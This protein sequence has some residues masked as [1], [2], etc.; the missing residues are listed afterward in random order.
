MR[1]FNQVDVLTIGELSPQ[2]TYLKLSCIGSYLPG[3]PTHD[4]P[5]IH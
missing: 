2:L 5:Q 1:Q 3:L 4:H